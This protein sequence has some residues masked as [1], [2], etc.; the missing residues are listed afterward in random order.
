[1]NLTTLVFEKT[2]N[3]NNELLGLAAS[4]LTCI[5][6]VPQVIQTW[7]TKNT[8]GVSL[9]AFVICAAGCALWLIYGINL[10]AFSIILTNTIVLI[11][12][13]VMVFLKLKYK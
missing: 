11:L 8:E 7:R 4:C 3:M 5:T 10:N 2:K 6:F 9:Q 13:L 12:S 1:V